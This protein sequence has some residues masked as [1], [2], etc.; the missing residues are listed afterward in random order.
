MKERAD[1]AYDDGRVHPVTQFMT[2]ASYFGMLGLS[3]AFLLMNVSQVP[4]ITLP[5]LSARNQNQVNETMRA[6]ALGVKHAH[7]MVKWS[8]PGASAKTK[9]LRAELVLD[10]APP[11]VTA[12]EK[13]MLE[14]LLSRGMDFTMGYDLNSVA[15]GETG[16][17]GRLLRSLNAPTHY[18]ELLNRGGT[19]LA[20]YRI[21][22]KQGKN[23]AAAIDFAQQAVD[24]THVNYEPSD[25]PR[26]MQQVLMFKSRDLARMAF[27]FM[28][29]QYGMI[30]LTLS[31][32]VDAL[33][34]NANAETRAQARATLAGLG[35][36]L[37]ATAGV[38]GL[39][40][41]S[42]I[43]GMASFFAGLIGSDDEDWDFERDIRNW[44]QDTMPGIEPIIS[45]GLLTTLTGADF[46]ARMGQGDF[47]NP[48]AYKR[49]DASDRG[50]D[51]VNKVLSAAFGAS[52][53]TVGSWLDALE[54]FSNGDIREGVEKSFPLKAV[55]D[56]AKAFELEQGGLTAG[57]EN[58]A[59]RPERIDTMDWVWQA[60]GVTPAKVSTYYE[61]N[62][63]I[64]G[65]KQAVMDVRADLLAEYAAA[66]R[67]G[68]PT[69][70]VMQ[71][72]ERFNAKHPHRS[73][74][75]THSA[76]LRAVRSRQ[77]VEKTR[78]PSGALGGREN[79]AFTPYGRFAN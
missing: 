8:A 4:M 16:F 5:W 59:I 17:K 76:L 54:A 14:T 3:P 18:T 21:A 42:T 68:K 49:F 57:K 39:P 53:S 64:Q 63:A 1:V 9:E 7:A 25:T 15:Q 37:T 31:S 75:I 2:Q 43:L 70:R 30:Y 67:D 10:Q 40:F 45:K 48:W 33:P 6:L 29:Y 47:L 19:A 20:A 36:T 38:F 61:Q 55:K 51:T 74:R 65:Q 73:I 71:K 23:A 50:Q 35:V 28:R 27:Q 77:Q 62:A 13:A 32:V 22:R 79:E 60:L 46:S 34:R 69:S 12:E 11:G 78:L 58:Q 52:G 24:T 26:Y 44:L 66:R 41:A 56:I 72:I